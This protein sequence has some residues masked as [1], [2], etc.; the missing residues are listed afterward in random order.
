MKASENNRKSH[1]REKNY[2]N[3]LNAAEEVFAQNGFKGSSMN[4]IAEKAGLPKANIHYYFSNKMAL[5]M[6]VLQRILVEWNQGL[7]EFTEQDDPSEVLEHYI[8]SKVLQACQKPHQSK[9]F[10]SEVISGAPAIADYIR[11]EMRQ[12]LRE[13]SAI[14]QIWMDK[15]LMKPVDPSHLMFMIWSTTQHYADYQTQVLL[16]LNQQEYE[17]SDYETIT[18]IVTEVIL[19]GVGL[20]PSW[21]KQ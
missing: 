3:I 8:A 21:K 13:K 16:L 4:A 14:F 11:T 6:E 19:T 12:W 5:Y 20:T 9:L 2:L 10:A 17:T 7:G 1:I 18:R 15:G